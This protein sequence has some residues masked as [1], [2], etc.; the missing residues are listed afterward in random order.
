[1]KEIRELI[2]YMATDT[3]PPR[4]QAGDTHESKAS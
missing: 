3:W 1:M 4:I 2:V